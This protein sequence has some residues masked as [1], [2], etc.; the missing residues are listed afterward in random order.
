MEECTWICGRNYQTECGHIY[1]HFV[2]SFNQPEIIDDIC[3]WCGKPIN[4]EDED[5]EDEDYYDDEDDEFD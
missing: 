5:D 3:P 1:F 2:K 4:Y